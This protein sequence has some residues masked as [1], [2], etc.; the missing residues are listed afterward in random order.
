MVRSEV[1]EIKST[2]GLL[3]TGFVVMISLVVLFASV[4]L[5]ENSRIAELN[6]KIYHHPFSVSNAVLEAN[7]DIIAMHRYM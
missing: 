6:D 3:I 5:Q 1:S 2:T 7:A 4:S